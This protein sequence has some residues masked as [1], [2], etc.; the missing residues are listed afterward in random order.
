MSRRWSHES[1]DSW[2]KWGRAESLIDEAWKR[3]QARWFAAQ[4]WVW[5]VVI[6]GYAALALLFLGRHP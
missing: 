3:R 1:G 6:G 5:S 4:V 2:S